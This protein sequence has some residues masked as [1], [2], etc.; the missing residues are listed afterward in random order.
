MW[1]S[2]SRFLAQASGAHH[3]G[4]RVAAVKRLD[5]PPEVV[6]EL[7]IVAGNR[8]HLYEHLKQGFAGNERSGAPQS[9]RR[10]TTGTFRNR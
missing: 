3:Q 8:A 7:I 5:D 4:R 2:L 10:N 9:P 1:T 6:R